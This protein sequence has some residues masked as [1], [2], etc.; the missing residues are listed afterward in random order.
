MVQVQVQ[1]HSRRRLITGVAPLI[2]RHPRELVQV[3]KMKA[4]DLCPWKKGG[5]E[6]RTRNSVLRAAARTLLFSGC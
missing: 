1:V 3:V 2:S 6:E 4:I 5:E